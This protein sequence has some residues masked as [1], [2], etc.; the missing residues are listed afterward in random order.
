MNLQKFNYPQYKIKKRKILFAQRL[1][2]LRKNLNISH[3]YPAKQ[4]GSP[5][6]KSKCEQEIHRTK[7]ILLNFFEQKNN[8]KTL[9]AFI[10]AH[11]VLTNFLFVLNIQSLKLL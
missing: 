2:E 5:Y 7:L 9:N 10:Y 4:I 6:T 3:N 11:L 1:K 8:V